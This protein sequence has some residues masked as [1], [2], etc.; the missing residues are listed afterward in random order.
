MLLALFASMT[1]LALACLAFTGYELWCSGTE[2]RGL[3]VHDE[4]VWVC[5]AL[6]VLMA[7]TA[8]FMLAWRM[9]H[10]IGDLIRH[11]I[12]RPGN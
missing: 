4:L 9:Q 5:A 10:V 8:A 2:Q 3:S 1:S 12:R 6:V 7:V 11:I